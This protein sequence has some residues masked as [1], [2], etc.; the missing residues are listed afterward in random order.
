MKNRF[1][2]LP[3]LFDPLQ[4]KNDL[5]LCNTFNWINHFNQND[6]SG[7][8][9]SISLR[10]ATG[11]ETDIYSHPDVTGFS[12]T[13]ALKQCGY[14]QSVIN[15]FECKKETVRLL[16]LAPG[17]AIKE[18]TDVQAGYEYD[19]F[20]IHIPVTTNEH[21]SFIV[22]GS[23]VPMKEGEC[24]YANF[25]LPHSI[26]NKGETD[27][28]HLII[29]CK[30]NE[31]SD[32]VFKQSGYDFEYEKKVLDYDLETKKRMIEE[33]AHLKTPAADQLIEKL[34][35]ELAKKEE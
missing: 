16:S 28:V 24:W 9:K 15:L 3:F 14:F 29:D 33:L 4:L 26:S 12:N 32:S 13:P 25:H 22:D 2:Q 23:E 18:H 11:S 31:W 7:N 34:Q 10:S 30:R 21:V 8:W 20:R 5:A 6:Y 1:F 35:K 19:F 27:R 17:S